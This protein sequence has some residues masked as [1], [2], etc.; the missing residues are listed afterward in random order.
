ML[1][2]TLAGAI[3]CRLTNEGPKGHSPLLPLALSPDAISLEVF[4]APVPLGD[5]RIAALWTQVEEQPLAAELRQKLAQNGMRAGIVGPNVPDE[6]AELLKLT[7]VPISADERSLVPLQAEEGIVLTVMQ[8]R[9]GERRD[10]VTSETY[11]KIALL[12]RVGSQVEGKTYYKAEGRLVLRVF[13]ESDARVRLELTPELH[14]GEF[15]NRVSGSDGIMHWKQE[16]QKQVFEELKLTMTLAPGQMFLVTC[17]S[18]LPGSIGHWFFTHD[19]RRNSDAKAV[20]I[21]R[22]AGQPRSFV[23]R[24]A[25][26]HRR[27]SI[28][29]FAP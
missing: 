16:R 17:S 18:D 8:P 25:Q 11:E 12:R 29:R 15:K 9:I 21:S 13:G 24:R 28:E 20:R 1:L 5:P 4:S 27:A 2:I 26:G 19:A 23:L 6:L 3:G 10:L 14:H 7:D 22:G